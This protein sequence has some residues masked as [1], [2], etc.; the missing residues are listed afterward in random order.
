[1]VTSN[2]CRAAVDCLWQQILHG[3]NPELVTELLR[4]AKLYEELA[5]ILDART[6]AKPTRSLAFH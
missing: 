2:D 1:M 3:A 6:M 4:L 5:E